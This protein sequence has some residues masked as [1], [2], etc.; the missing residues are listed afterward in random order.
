MWFGTIFITIG[1]EM[2]FKV[3]LIKNLKTNTA[4]NSK[5]NTETP[6]GLFWIE[7]LVW[8]TRFWKAYVLPF[9]DFFAINLSKISPK[10]IHQ[11]EP[12]FLQ[13]DINCF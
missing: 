2:E 6:F 9:E 3:N 11:I 5:K 13:F 8:A 12:E 4:D 1:F 7:I 10:T